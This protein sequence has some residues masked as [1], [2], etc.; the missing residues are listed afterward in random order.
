MKVSFEITPTG[1]HLSKAKFRIGRQSVEPFSTAPWY[2][3]TEAKKLIPLLR[4]LRGDFFCAPFGHGPAWR[5]EDHPPHGES[6]NSAWKVQSAQPGRLI[7]T[8]Q[9]RVRP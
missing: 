6:A 5:G 2:G 7:A 8:L 4:A 9:T 3:E 1:G